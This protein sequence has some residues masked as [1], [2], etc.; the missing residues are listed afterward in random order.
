MRKTFR[1]GDWEYK[2]GVESYEIEILK[3]LGKDTDVTIPARINGKK[4]YHLD[5]FVFS[6]SPANVNVKRVVFSEG[7]E[8]INFHALSS[9]GIQEVVLPSTMQHIDDM[10]F[11]ETVQRAIVNPNNPYFFDIDGV[12]FGGRETNKHL[13]YFPSGHMAKTYR[14]PDGTTHID[15]YAFYGIKNLE[16]VIM[17]D[18]VVFLD[19]FPFISCPKLRSVRLSPNI[20]ELRESAFYNCPE[21]ADVKVSRKIEMV[22]PNAFDMCPKFKGINIQTRMSEQE[23]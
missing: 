21:L 23:R 8:R 13:V 17:P 1:F 18:S 6:E 15:W 7:L 10:G 12:V 20:G 5:S 4:V 11:G 22:S 2:K 9:S 3:Y 14:I 19:G 16:H